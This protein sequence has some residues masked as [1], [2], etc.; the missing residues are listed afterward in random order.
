MREHKY[1]L[2]IRLDHLVTQTSK[3][4]INERMKLFYRMLRAF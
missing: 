4:Q 2:E 1:M 3:Q